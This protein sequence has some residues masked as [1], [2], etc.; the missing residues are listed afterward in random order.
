MLHLLGMVL[1][2]YMYNLPLESTQPVFCILTHHYLQKRKLSQEHLWRSL[3]NKSMDFPV[4]G[5]QGTL[6]VSPLDIILWEYIPLELFGYFFQ[7]AFVLGVHISAILPKPV[8]TKN[9]RMSETFP[10][11]SCRSHMSTKSQLQQLCQANDISLHS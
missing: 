5:G 4:I 2:Y 1:L 7:T 8:P 9:I 10:N 11:V 3:S 6:S